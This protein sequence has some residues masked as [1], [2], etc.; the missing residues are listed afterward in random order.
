MS[1]TLVAGIGNIFLSDDA[2]GC[3]VVRRMAGHELPDHVTVVDFGIKG[4]HLAYELLNGY[5]RLILIDAIAR[6]SPWTAPGRSHSTPSL[7]LSLSR[8][9]H[10][11]VRSLYPALPMLQLSMK[12]L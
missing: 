3:E 5:D 7:S 8:S 2:F 1:G 11:R 10:S 4:I 12:V 9:L 6:N